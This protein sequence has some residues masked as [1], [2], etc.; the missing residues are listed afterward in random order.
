MRTDYTHASKTPIDNSG[1]SDTS[2]WSSSNVRSEIDNALKALYI[3][4]T[5]TDVAFGSKVIGTVLSDRR[6]LS[7]IL[8]ITTTFDDNVTCT[9]GD[10]SAQG[11]L[12]SADES[13]L[14]IT[15]VFQS[16]NTYLYSTE[17]ELSVY[18][19]ASTPTQ[20]VGQ[21]TIFYQ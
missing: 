20:G 1:T 8:Y 3:E 14:A 16:F 21:I 6:I 19:S 12:M 13:D 4:F 9:I 7:T 18:F 11:R 10:S 17:T 5:H 2:V 15:E